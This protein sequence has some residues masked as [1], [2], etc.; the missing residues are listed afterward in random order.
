MGYRLEVSKI[1]YVYCGGKLYG[2]VSEEKLK[3][4]K[5]YQWL[6]KKG[7]IDGDEYWSYGCNPQIVLRASEFRE[8][9]K[10]YIDDRDWKHDDL[11]LEELMASDGFKLLEW[12]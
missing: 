2:Y 12:F 9:M 5:S 6:L 7:Y 3:Q 1:D 4:L 8:F 11:A 10:L